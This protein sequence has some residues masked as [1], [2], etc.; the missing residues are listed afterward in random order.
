MRF[1][2][3]TTAVG[4]LIDGY[5]KTATNLDDGVAH[6]LFSA[7]RW[8]ARTA[9]LSKLASGTTLVVDRYAYSGV[10]FTAAKRVPG[11]DAAWAAAPDA[12]RARKAATTT[13]VAGTDRCCKA[14]PFRCAGPR[15]SRRRL[16]G[17]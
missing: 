10:A 17:F 3:R 8:E 12:E 16:R 13:P 9:L 4:T 1:P 2:D 7:N 6:L 11:L 14:S 5:L 15:L